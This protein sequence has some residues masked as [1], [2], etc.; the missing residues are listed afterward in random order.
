VFT[1]VISLFPFCY[2]AENEELLSELEL[3]VAELEE[4]LDVADDEL[5]LE[6]L[7]EL[8]YELH[9]LLVMLLDELLEL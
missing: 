4:L 1:L 6:L 5:E 9:E 3:D 8:E 7:D 2:G